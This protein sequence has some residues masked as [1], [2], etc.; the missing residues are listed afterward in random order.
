MA[1][2]NQRYPEMEKYGFGDWEGNDS[3]WWGLPGT[4]Q[5]PTNPLLIKQS[6]G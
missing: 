1:P 6:P 2:Q 5:G 4:E 3:A